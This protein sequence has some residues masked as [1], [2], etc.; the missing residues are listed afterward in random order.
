M[1]IHPTEI[2]LHQTSRILEVA[3]EDGARFHLPCEYLRVFSPSAEVRGHGPG[4]ETLMT[5]KEQVNIAA[6]EPVGHYAVKLVFDDG[7]NTGLY[8]WNVLY[9]LGVNQESHWQD[10][11]RRLAET[12]YERQA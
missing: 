11:L 12:G 6:I 9:D 5:G 10:Y 8:S 4:T 7:H 2:K 3:F 1:S